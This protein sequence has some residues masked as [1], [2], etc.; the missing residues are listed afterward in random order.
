MNCK[1][2]LDIGDNYGD[3]SATMHCQLLAGHKGTHQEKWT[4]YGSRRGLVFFA[5]L[6]WYQRKLKKEVKP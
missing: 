1:A 3:N 4:G 6:I 2:L 5:T